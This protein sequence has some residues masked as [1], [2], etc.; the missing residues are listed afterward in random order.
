MKY[1]LTILLL[2]SLGTIHAQFV[3]T[4]S[5]GSNSTL[6]KSRGGLGADS[7]I[8]FLNS[9]PDT[10][11]ANSSVASKYNSI[12]RVGTTYWY[13][14]LSP[15]KW[16]AFSSGVAGSY[17]QYTDTALMLSAYYNKT[18]ANAL[19]NLK[20]NYTDTS[21]MLSPYLRSALGV[22]YSDTAL[23][24]TPYYRAS[25]PSGYI[26]ASAITGKVNYTDTA[27]M[28]TPY[29]RSSLASTTYVPYV[30]ATTNVNIGTNSYLGK[31]SIHSLISG[32]DSSYYS[33]QN[34]VGGILKHISYASGAAG[35]TFGATNN[36]LAALITSPSGVSAFAIGT[37]NAI[38]LI[39]GINGTESMRL[40]YSTGHLLI[41][42]TADNTLGQLLQVN[43]GIYASSF[44]KSGG[45]SAQF[46]MADGSISTGSLTWNGQI[47]GGTGATSPIALL[48]YDNTSSSFKQLAAGTANQVLI[49]NGST[50]GWGSTVNS[51]TY[52][53]TMTN[54]T[55][56][57]SI[58]PTQAVWSQVG[59]IVTVSGSFSISMTSGSTSTQFGISLPVAA[60]SLTGSDLWGLVFNAD[61]G[62]LYAGET[63]YINGDATNKR[64]TVSFKAS[65]STSGGG[66]FQ[67]QYYAH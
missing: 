2:V 53:P 47:Y 11:T 30:G 27:S 59:N 16:N 31:N 46:L 25:N 29:L 41:G 8:V 23:M 20:V 14:T 6:F 66:N 35:T 38:P 52:T 13:R 37:N 21:L 32:T 18:A 42:T 1:I 3:N 67:F 55:N 54:V 60:A 22:K 28:L 4:A 63:G 5:I 43:G 33:S 40:H 61:S 58:T 62:G 12:I 7:A 15:N 44:V 51:G 49:S 57:S 34:D 39:F 26:S 64:A 45:T 9:F 10:T 17:V 19:Y 36:S 50:F 65:S 48:V 56:V 24:L